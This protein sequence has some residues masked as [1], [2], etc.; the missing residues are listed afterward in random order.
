MAKTATNRNDLLREE[1]IFEV[2]VLDG[3]DGYARLDKDDNLE[4]FF[5]LDGIGKPVE[6][7]EFFRDEQRNS[8]EEAAK[9]CKYEKKEPPKDEDIYERGR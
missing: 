5:L 4:E 2:N 7:L 9:E 1:G 3:L 8:I 6:I